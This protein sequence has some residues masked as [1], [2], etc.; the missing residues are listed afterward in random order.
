MI[1]DIKDSRLIENR[2]E[3]QYLI[4]DMLEEANLTFSDI[5][6]CPFAISSG[7]EW[8]GL[9]PPDCNYQILLNFFRSKLGNI[10]F[11]CGMGKGKI[12]IDDFFLPANQLDGPAFYLARKAISLA[13]EM[14][15]A[16]V[17]ITRDDF[18][19]FHENYLVDKG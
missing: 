2:K 3:I 8:E 13:K 5:I 12:T 1:C 18:N 7:D 4:I 9:L 17:Y 14:D 6:L 19:S 11:Y 16:V 15:T 10:R